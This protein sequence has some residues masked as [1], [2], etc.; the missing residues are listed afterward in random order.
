MSESTNE[1]DKHYDDVYVKGQIDRKKFNENEIKKAAQIN[2]ENK[3]SI[4]IYQHKDKLI[5]VTDMHGRTFM[6]TKDESKILK[7]QGQIR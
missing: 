3:K 7:E 2:E 4:G 5:K 1:H 6:T